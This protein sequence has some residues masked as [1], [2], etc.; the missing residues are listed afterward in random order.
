MKYLLLMALLLPSTVFAHMS[1]PV[2]Q[3]QSAS[4]PSSCKSARDQLARA[5]QL[6]VGNPDGDVLERL[7]IERRMGVPSDQA[8]SCMVLAVWRDHVPQHG[9]LSLVKAPNGVLVNWDPFGY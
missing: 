4:F 6:T 7:Q 3:A 5:L 9:L 8:L 1:E 2:Q